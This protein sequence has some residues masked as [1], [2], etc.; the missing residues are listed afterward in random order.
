MT[1]P[2]G[3][4]HCGRYLFIAGGGPEAEDQ[5]RNAAPAPPVSKIGGYRRMSS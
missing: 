4:P 1:G 2:Q 5:N 3:A